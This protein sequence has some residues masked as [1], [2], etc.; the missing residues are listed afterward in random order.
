MPKQLPVDPNAPPPLDVAY[1]QAAAYA[2]YVQGG[3]YEQIAEQ[4]RSLPGAPARYSKRHAHAD[5][6]SIIR[7]DLQNIP[8]HRDNHPA[9]KRVQ[10]ERLNQLFSGIWPYALKGDPGSIN[11]VLKLM[12]RM[13]S[14]MGLFPKEEAANQPRG[15]SMAGGNAAPSTELPRI[16]EVV[17][18]LPA[19]GGTSQVTLM[20]P[21]DPRVIDVT[22]SQNGGNGSN[23]S[24]GSN[25]HH[26]PGA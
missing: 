10:L 1:R 6:E 18:E 11:V 14:Y 24:N 15:A 3:S 26:E 22:P 20:M 5:I 9:H 2:L 8:D 23:G 7:D 13:D 25:G 19:P 12:E 21:T 4:I 17:V 16:R